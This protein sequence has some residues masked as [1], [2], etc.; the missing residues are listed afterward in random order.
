MTTII[1]TKDAVERGRK[2][3][4]ASLG[5]QLDDIGRRLDEATWAWKEA[6]YP[7]SGVEYDTREAVFADLRAWNKRAAGPSE[8]NRWT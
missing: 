3:V 4:V 1:P 8:P 5:E 7:S 2:I 6:G